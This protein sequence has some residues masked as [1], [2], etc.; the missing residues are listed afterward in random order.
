VEAEAEAETERQRDRDRDR[1]R[2]RGRD[3]DRD[4]DR[5]RNRERERDERASERA[6]EREREREVGDSKVGKPA[7]GVLHGHERSELQHEAEFFARERGLARVPDA[8]RKTART[9]MS[10]IA[11]SATEQWLR[12]TK[13]TF[14]P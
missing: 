10:S 7:S 8:A 5:D 3:R 12:A 14:T 2:K 9:C 13:S 6:R 1:G 4:R 11:M